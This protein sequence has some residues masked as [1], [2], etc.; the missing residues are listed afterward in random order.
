M[1]K[2]IT[3]PSLASEICEACCAHAGSLPA[4]CHGFLTTFAEFSLA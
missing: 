3:E 4:R 1:E 2:A